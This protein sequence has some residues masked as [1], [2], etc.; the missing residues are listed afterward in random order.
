MSDRKATFHLGR[1]SKKLQ[2]AGCIY[3]EEEAFLLVSA[4]HS[5]AEL[6][7]MVAKRSAG[8]PL[9]HVIGWAEFCGLK[10]RVDRNVFV[11]RRRTEFL[12]H[13]AGS[14]VREGAIVVDLCCGSGAIGA[15]LAASIGSI[16]LHAT[17]IDS[18]AVH[19]ACRNLAS[20]G[21]HIYEGD[22]YEPLPAALKG[23]I[24]LIV[25]NVPYVPTEMLARLPAEARL[26]EAREAHD[27]GK[28]GLAMHRKAAAGAVTWL[29]PSGCFM[30][31]ANIRQAPQIVEILS[32]HGLK[33]EVARSEELD[34]T[35]IIGKPSSA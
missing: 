7:L 32:S 9:E 30:A 3:A 10:I 1:I 34:A 21:A 31:E 11:P 13:Q 20:I 23:K 29:A 27:G 19:C 26:Y 18:N 8:E 16:E 35:V 28:D 17:D 14:A 12:V 24:D 2:S 33:T 22:L 25:A 15:A 4:A 5:P 6:A